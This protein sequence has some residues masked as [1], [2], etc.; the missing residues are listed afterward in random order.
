[1]FSN[2]P[3]VLT[4]EQVAEALNICI[5]LAYR[6]IKEGQLGYKRIGRRILIPKVCLVDYISSAR[7]S[8]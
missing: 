8:L 7:T 4:V 1:M 5:G 3:D 2:Y 6:L